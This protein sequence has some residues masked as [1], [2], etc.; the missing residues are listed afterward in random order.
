[1]RFLII[2]LI[3]ILVVLAILYFVVGNYFYNIALNP[4]TS[5]S[6]VLGEI[7][8]TVDIGER[9]L[10]KNSESVYITSSN[11]GNL[12][13]QGYEVKQDSNIGAIVVHGYY[14]KGSD[15]SFL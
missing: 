1:M 3:I 9:W 5:K 15:M 13:L 2:I 7:D 6:Y 12:R 10:S 11:N 8:K 14:G 4:K